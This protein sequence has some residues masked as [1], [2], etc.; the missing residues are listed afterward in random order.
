MG[1]K[2]NRNFKRCQLKVV[3]MAQYYKAVGDTT[4]TCKAKPPKD[5]AY[6]TYSAAVLQCPKTREFN[7]SITSHSQREKLD[8]V[9]EL[10]EIAAAVVC[11][12]CSLSR[13]NPVQYEER[14]AEILRAKAERQEAQNRLDLAD[15]RAEYIQK[16]GEEE[17]RKI[18]E[19]PTLD[20]PV[21]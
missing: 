6:D 12:S 19:S 17:L 11:E 10:P 3:K 9:N 4:N 14:Q 7:L 8:A 13:L 21:T 18:T 5:G 16:L 20:V 2:G 1:R 15:K